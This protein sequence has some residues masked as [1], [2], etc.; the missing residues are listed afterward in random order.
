MLIVRIELHSAVTGQVS[1]IA[2][3][4][5]VNDGTGT[6]TRGNYK[7][8]VLRGR[9]AAEFNR[10]TVA[11]SGKVNNYPR[12]RLHVWNLVCCALDAIGYNPLEHA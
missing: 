1:E 7:C 8:R 3:M 9:C 4:E 5:I 6:Q 2:R 12:L 11:K 10:R